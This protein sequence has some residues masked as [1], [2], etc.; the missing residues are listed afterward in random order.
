MSQLRSKLAVVLTVVALGGLAAVALS[1]PQ[2]PPPATHVQSTANAVHPVAT[3]T[4]FV[5]DEGG[6]ADD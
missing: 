6:G 1:H 3:H 2:P 5:D 4:T